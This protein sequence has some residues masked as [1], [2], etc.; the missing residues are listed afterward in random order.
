MKKRDGIDHIDEEEEEREEEAYL[1]KVLMM[2]MKSCYLLV[3][4]PHMARNRLLPFRYCKLRV[5]S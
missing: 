1:E 5:S 4:L 2:L 3:I